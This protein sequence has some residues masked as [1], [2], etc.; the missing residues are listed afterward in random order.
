MRT[1]LADVDGIVDA[2]VARAPAG[3]RLRADVE[4]SDPR[5]ADGGGVAL[6]L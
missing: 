2:G 6:E 4:A 5:A 1:R 3:A